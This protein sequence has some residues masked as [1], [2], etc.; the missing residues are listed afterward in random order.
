MTVWFLYHFTKLRPI[1]MGLLL[2]YKYQLW[3][4]WN[5][6]L[7]HGKVLNEN[8]NGTKSW[9]GISVVSCKGNTF[10]FCLKL[11]SSFGCLYYILKYFMND[12]SY[13]SAF[14]ILCYLNYIQSQ[15]LQT[16]Q[17]PN[18]K[19]KWYA[20]CFQGL[21][22]SKEQSSKVPYMPGQGKMPAHCVVE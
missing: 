10:G 14:L 13:F 16:K 20:V 12:F 2:F 3:K 1:V 21:V 11:L 18:Y 5:G 22:V 15:L 9:F 7:T 17:C 6:H 4:F 19:P 8:A